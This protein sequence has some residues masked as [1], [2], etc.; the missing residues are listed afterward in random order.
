MDKDHELILKP[1]TIFSTDPKLPSL[2]GRRCSHGRGA[3]RPLEGADRVSRSAEYPQRF[4]RCLAKHFVPVMTAQAAYHLVTAAAAE[5]QD[6][7]RFPPGPPPRRAG[8]GARGELDS[9]SATTRGHLYSSP[10]LQPGPPART[11]SG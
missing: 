8:G 3:H 7:E 11:C 1:W 6:Q 4:C 9:C 5:A 2:L 10:A